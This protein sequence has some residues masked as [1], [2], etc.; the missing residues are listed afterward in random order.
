[1]EVLHLCVCL[2][3]HMEGRRGHRI[4]TGKITSVSVISS[5]YIHGHSELHPS[6]Q[7]APSTLKPETD[8]I[9]TFDLEQIRKPSKTFARTNLFY[10]YND[11]K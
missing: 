7:K 10:L 1:M 5:S 4:S 11:L 8:I 6:L 3:L 2:L 9:T